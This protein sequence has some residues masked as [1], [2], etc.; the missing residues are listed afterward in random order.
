MGNEYLKV[1]MSRNAAAK[2]NK[3]A[4]NTRG[5]GVGDVQIGQGDNLWRKS[6]QQCYEKLVYIS[7]FLN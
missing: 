5:G 7:F 6:N 2:A 1:K 3:A 4:E